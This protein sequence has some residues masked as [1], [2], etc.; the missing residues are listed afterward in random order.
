MSDKD[1]FSSACAPAFCNCN[2]F[3]WPSPVRCLTP[4]GRR[5]HRLPHLQETVVRPLNF[6]KITITEQG[7]RGRLSLPIPGQDPGGVRARAGCGANAGTAK[8]IVW[9]GLQ[10]A[11]PS[12]PDDIDIF[13][14]RETR[15]ARE[16]RNV[17]RGLGTAGTAPSWPRR[18]G[19]CA[20]PRASGARRPRPAHL[21]A[22]MPRP[23]GNCTLHM[24]GWPPSGARTRSSSNGPPATSFNRFQ[25]FGLATG[26]MPLPRHHSM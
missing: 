5:L 16:N 23:R 2:A 15:E 6:F 11:V 14:G 12:V 7:H 8:S 25:N 21:H 20:V 10:H 17:Y 24:R 26:A 18:C 19:G 4:Q 13:S 1:V 22:A 3:R 9:R